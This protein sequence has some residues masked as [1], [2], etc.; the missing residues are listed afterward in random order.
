EEAELKDSFNEAPIALHWL[1]ANGKV[2]WVNDRELEML[3]YSREEY[4]GAEMT[5]FCPD[6]ADDILE[7]FKLLGTG[8]TI[9]DVPVRFRT[10]A[11][12]VQDVLVD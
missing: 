1:C 7:I 11:G 2:L 12:K 6:S 9:R 10:K 8:S 5:S 3:G 4:V